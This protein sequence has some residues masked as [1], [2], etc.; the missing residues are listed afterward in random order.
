M[1]YN[2]KTICQ[3]NIFFKFFFFFWLML[4]VVQEIVFDTLLWDGNGMGQGQRMG[5]L[6]LAGMILSYFISVLLHMTEKIFLSHPHLLEPWEALSHPV[7][8]YFF[9]DLPPQLLQFFFNKTC[10]INK[11]ILKIS[12]KFIPSDQTNF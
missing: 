12:T 5:F 11:N 6:F 2:K 4:N 9:V 10:F 7:K 8:L 1:A 3:L